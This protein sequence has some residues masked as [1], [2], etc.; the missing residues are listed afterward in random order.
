MS[1]AMRFAEADF[2]LK[3]ALAACKRYGMST[4]GYTAA[5]LDRLTAEFEEAR[6][7]AAADIKPAPA[8]WVPDTEKEY[9]LRDW[10]L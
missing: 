7:A 5:D 9:I 3:K 2:Q 1:N 8:G 6:K 10:G 4:A